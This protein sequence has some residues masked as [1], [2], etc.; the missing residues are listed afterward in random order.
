MVRQTQIVIQAPV[1]NFF[2]I[3]LHSW[4]YIPFQFGE[5]KIIFRKM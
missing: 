3:E 5:E 1:Q 4:A 2:T